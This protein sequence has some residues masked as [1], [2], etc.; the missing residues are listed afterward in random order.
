MDG[1]FFLIK[2]ILM[3]KHYYLN[4]QVKPQ[5]QGIFVRL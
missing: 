1:K 3:H 5:K 4:I 2:K